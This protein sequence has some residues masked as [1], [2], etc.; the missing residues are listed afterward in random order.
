MI[1]YMHSGYAESL[2]EFGVPRK[3]PQCEGWILER[4]IP[5]FPYHD[6]MS[7]YPLFACQD[8]SQLRAD[9]EDIGTDLVSLALVTDPFGSYDPAYLQS[10]FKDVVFPFKEHFV[11]ELGPSPD[12]F[13]SSHHRRYARKAA[14]QLDIEICE[15]PAEFLDDWVELYT[16]LTERHNIK[17]ISA[18]SRSAFTKQLSLPG[19]VAFRAIYEAATVG[20]LLW[21]VQG[22][23][24]YYHLG[25]YN[26][27]GYELR[28]SFALFW[29][30]IE[31]FTKEG[32][33]SL[34]LGAGAGVTNNGS[35]GLSRFKQGWSTGTRTAY[36]CGHIFDQAKYLEIIQAK[37]VSTNNGYFPAYRKGE[38]S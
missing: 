26:L 35:D 38:F 9:L 15:N 29:R 37:D 25:A 12:T 30:V 13:V 14:Q 10:C 2:S 20:M 36:F 3:L 16:T 21:Y 5:G 23:V 4:P 18:F 8:W 24:G 32:L 22:E 1:G 7:C 28:A 19:I 17:G 27:L 33:R 31:Y 11:I 34:S 6:G